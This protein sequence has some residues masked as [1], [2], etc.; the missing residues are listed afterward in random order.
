M[1]IYNGKSHI[2]EIEESSKN[3]KRENELKKIKLRKIEGKMTKEDILKNVVGIY[4][5]E[6]SEYYDRI[7]EKG[8]EIHS[9]DYN[10]R[11]RMDDYYQF[12]MNVT[13]KNKW[14]MLLKYSYDTE[15]NETCY[16]LNPDYITDDKKQKINYGCNILEKSNKVI[17]FYE[18][19]DNGKDWFVDKYYNEPIRELLKLKEKGF[20]V[21]DVIIDNLDTNYHIKITLPEFLFSQGLLWN[22]IKK[23]SYNRTVDEDKKLILQT[24]SYYLNIIESYQGDNIY[25]ISTNSKL[26]YDDHKIDNNI[27]DHIIK[28]ELPIKKEQI[29]ENLI[30]IDQLVFHNNFTNKDL[31]LELSHMGYFR[32]HELLEDQQINCSLEFSFNRRYTTHDPDHFCVYGYLNTDIN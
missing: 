22:P 12:V 25:C 31:Q 13:Y 16:F 24:H 23:Y 9:I 1:V 7:T 27:S 3:I 15:E 10:V 30:R 14:N 17:K 29:E 11:I 32:Q 5:E 18:L 4:E 19:L 20:I 2:E 8:F 28:L 6:I 21:D 26:S